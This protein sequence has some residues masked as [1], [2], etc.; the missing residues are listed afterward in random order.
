[1]THDFCNLR[2][3]VP[4]KIPVVFHNGSNYDYY[5]IFKELAKE[6]EGQF[7][8]HGEITEKYKTLSIP[9]EKQDKR[10]YQILLIIL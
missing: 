1:M 3:N 7:E 2:F 10:H 5:F 6:F 9:I 8:C 4:N